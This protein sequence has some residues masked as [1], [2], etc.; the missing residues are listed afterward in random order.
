MRAGV[1][2]VFRKKALHHRSLASQAV[3]TAPAMTDMTRM[4]DDPASIPRTSDSCSFQ[5][6]L[7]VCGRSI[8]DRRVQTFFIVEPFDPIHDIKSRLISRGVSQP[9][10]AFDFERLEEALH[11]CII[12][13]IALP[14]HRLRHVKLLKEF[15]V[16]VAGVLAPASRRHH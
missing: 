6:A 4:L 3:Y 15:A 14:A 2:P 5:A 1:E 12:P 7:E 10:R 16:L 9:V 8:V 13:A 11:W